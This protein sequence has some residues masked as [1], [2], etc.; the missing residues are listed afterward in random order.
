MPFDLGKSVRLAAQCR[1]PGGQLTTA[2]GAVLTITQPDGTT[3]LPVVPV[4]ASAGQ[5][6]VDWVPAM[7]G[8]HTVCW[9]FTNPADA[10]ND[11]LDVRPSTALAMFSLADAKRQVNLPADV[12]RDDDELREWAASAT[13]AVE[14]FVGAVVQRTVTA[15]VTGGRPSLVLP[16]TPVIAVTSI[17]PVTTVQQSIDAGVLTTDPGTGVVN[18]TDGL[19][20]PPGLYR[21]VYS[22]GR[23][24]VT[25]NITSA[26]RLILQHLWRTQRGGSRATTGG[27]DD[28]S[29]SEPI[30]GLGYAIP[31]RAL[32]LLQADLEVGGFA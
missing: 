7:A 28:W 16:I 23:R 9:Q 8:L 27:G 10:Y 32:Q 31:N 6:V 29:V 26:G 14:Y 20:F 5:Y 18:R 11:V 22:A 15:I 3:A 30:P 19:A 21:I 4:P 13:A 17:V 25:A 1:D 12:T 24:I 2:T